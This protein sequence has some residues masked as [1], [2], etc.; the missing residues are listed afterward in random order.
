MVIVSTTL[1]DLQDK[2]GHAITAAGTLLPMSDLIRMAAHAWH[3]L[4]I[5]DQV[6]GRPLWLGRTKRIA[7]PDQRIVLHAKDRGCTAPGCSAPGYLAEVHHVQDW[8]TGGKTNIDQLTFAC[9]PHHQLLDQGWTTR[10][11]PNGDTQWIPPPQLPLPSGTNT[12]HHPEKLHEDKDDEA[13]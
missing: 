5:F 11:L 1:Q 4:S 9:K 6:T 3:Y 12:Y 10:K 8:A 13:A 7:T 2:A